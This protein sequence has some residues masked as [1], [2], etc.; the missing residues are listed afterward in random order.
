MLY[1]FFPEFLNMSL[2]ASIVILILVLLRPLLRRTPHGVS[3]LL[4]GVALF[5]LICPISFSSSFTLLHGTQTVNNRIEYLPTA[6]IE[7]AMH[8]SKT[9][10][11]SV[12]A[13]TVTEAASGTLGRTDFAH[14]L[15]VTGALC[16]VIGIVVFLLINL[17]S[18]LRLHRQCIGAVKV[19]ENVYLADDIQTPF[20]LGIF[21]P[22]I[23]LP[24]ALTEV[25]QQLILQH[26]RTHIK[27]LDPLWKL[28]AFLALCIHWFNPI[29][30]L[31]F[32]FFVRDMETSCDEQ[33]LRSLTTDERADYAET[34]LYLSTGKRILSVSPAFGE[35]SP[36]T[37]IKRIIMY[38][39]P[40]AVVSAAAAVLAIVL[41]VLLLANPKTE[42]GLAGEIIPEMP[43]SAS[44]H[45]GVWIANDPE[46]DENYRDA[47]YGFYGVGEEIT[48]GI[49]YSLQNLEIETIPV[50]ESRTEDRD[51]SNSLSF[52][53]MN[54]ISDTVFYFNSDFSEIWI[55]NKVKPSYTYAVKDPDFVREIFT[56]L[57]TGQSEN[58]LL[59]AV[60]EAHRIASTEQYTTVIYC[61]PMNQN[62]GSIKIGTVHAGYITHYLYTSEWT[63]VLAVK[64]RLPSPESVEFVL[65]GNYRIQIWK[66]P[67]RAVIRNGEKE[68]WFKTPSNA[69]SDAVDVAIKYALKPEE[70]EAQTETEANTAST[71][72]EASASPT[73]TPTMSPTPEP[74]A[75]PE[76]NGEAFIESET[77]PEPTPNSSPTDETYVDKAESPSGINSVPEVSPTMSPTPEPTPTPA[78]ETETE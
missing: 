35:D 62:S 51:K 23:Y 68:T 60:F 22:R 46:H 63:Q 41:G 11:A 12:V 13:E 58:V 65:G 38:K 7:D 33:V 48:S 18:M 16:W 52:G 34:L 14:F 30:W 55:D 67:R 53:T 45:Y 73:A 64:D 37:R 40:L 44:K 77:Q 43:D 54:G 71:V 59:N 75:T 49:L 26:E 1:S 21:K 76:P 4:W 20:V 78:S 56:F 24:S 57:L 72:T 5:R 9:P 69:Y 10:A 66:N 47:S 29:V 3:M 31:G 2:T 42:T 32:H 6:L 39:K 15:L 19:E 28:I 36:K 8:L 50:S 74:T 25:Q 27:R 70:L 61:P 17:F